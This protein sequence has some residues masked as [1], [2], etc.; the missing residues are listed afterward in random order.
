MA[1]IATAT[2]KV[3][4]L[5][6]NRTRIN[7]ENFLHHYRRIHIQLIPG[8]NE[9]SAVLSMFPQKS[10]KPYALSECICCYRLLRTLNECMSCYRLYSLLINTTETLTGGRHYSTRCFQLTNQISTQVS[11]TA[12]YLCD[13]LPSQL[14]SAE[15]S[16]EEILG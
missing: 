7:V 8:K 2:A 6:P 15:N 4:L 5:E 9:K 11:A 12:Q 14:Q 10:K 16:G 3:L 13:D 1:A